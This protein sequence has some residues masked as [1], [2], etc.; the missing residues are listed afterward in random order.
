LDEHWR[1][2]G[3]GGVSPEGTVPEWARV[4]AHVFVDD[5]MN[6]IAIPPGDLRG[7]EMVRQWVGRATLH[8]IHAAFPPLKVTGHERRKDSVSLKKCLK[9]DARFETDKVMLGFL[10]QGGT[11]RNRLVGLPEDKAIRYRDTIQEALDRPRNFISFNAFEQLHGKLQ[12]ALIALP[13]MRG[14]MT[15]LN[16]ILGRSPTT[17]GLA[18][19]SETREVL[20]QFVFMITLS[21]ERPSHISDLVSPDLPHY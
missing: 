16:K 2:L 20:E 11:H 21:Y 7:R 13:A 8:A 6:G 17:V 4:S 1:P 14:Y 10:L 18:R 9:G 3:T 15:P 12:H 19:G 5:F